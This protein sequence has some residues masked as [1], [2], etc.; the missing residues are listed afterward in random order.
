MQGRD[1]SFVKDEAGTPASRM[2][3]NEI[4]RCAIY[5]ELRMTARSLLLLTCDQQSMQS[6]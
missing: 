6:A 1:F 4:L 5:G 3:K 2:T